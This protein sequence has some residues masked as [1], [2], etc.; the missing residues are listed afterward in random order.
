MDP[1]RV[2]NILSFLRTNIRTET[3]TLRQ[4]R[5]FVRRAEGLTVRERLC[6]ECALLNQSQME[7]FHKSLVSRSVR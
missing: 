1:R 3:E 4:A 6:L 7:A 2:S 5:S